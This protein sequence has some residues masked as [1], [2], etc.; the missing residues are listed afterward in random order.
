[1]DDDSNSASVM[2]STL[3]RVTVA[4]F[5]PVGRFV[6]EQL[7]AAGV[8]V[9]IIDLNP[10]T[11]ATQSKLGIKAVLGDVTDPKVLMEAGIE[12]ADALILAVPNEE[13]AVRACSEARRLAPKL[14]IAARTNFV[15]RG[16]LATK[17][18]ADHVTIEELVTAQAMR[19]AVVRHFF[20]DLAGEK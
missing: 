4:G 17:A 14:F 11:I 8:E 10:A 6:T 19:D 15:S 7:R 3:R 5:G 16:L 1:M 2:P 12:Q 20:E 13:A 18:G 9:T